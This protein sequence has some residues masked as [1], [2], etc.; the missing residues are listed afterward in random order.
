M[1]LSSCAEP[2]VHFDGS[3][4]VLGPPKRPDGSSSNRF[5]QRTIDRPG[6]TPTGADRGYLFTYDSSGNISL[7]QCLSP[8]DSA[9]PSVNTRRRTQCHCTTSISVLLG[10]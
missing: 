6:S 5:I 8:K 1:S 3:A 2:I 10:H 4:G 9:G 7:A